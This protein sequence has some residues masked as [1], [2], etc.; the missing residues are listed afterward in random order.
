MC[1]NQTIFRVEMSWHNRQQYSPTQRFEKRNPHPL[2]SGV[3]P[4]GELF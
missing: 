3:Y 1:T 4:E 2:A